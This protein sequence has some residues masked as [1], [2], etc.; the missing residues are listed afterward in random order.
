M[1][2]LRK[3]SQS[4]LI[5][6]SVIMLAASVAGYFIIQAVIENET[7]EALLQREEIIVK[8]IS[9]TGFLPQLYPIIEV[10]AIDSLTGSEP[11]FSRVWLTDDSEGETEAYIEYVRQVRIRDVN[12]VIILRQAS[13]ESEDTITALAV[14]LL[15]LLFLAFATSFLLTGRIN[16][17]MWTDFEK[18]LKLIENFSFIK[19]A[20][21][22]LRKSGIEE[23]NRLNTVVEKLTHRLRHDY[24]S[25]KEFTENASHE[26]QTPLS[27]TLINLEEILQQDIDEKTFRIVNASIA[28]LKK[29]S[30]LNK[31]LILLTKIENG[32]FVANN[33]LDLGTTIN[34][35]LEE[36][37]SL[38]ESKQI[39]VEFQQK[40]NFSVKMNE[41]LAEVLAGN[42]LSNAIRHNVQGGVVRISVTPEAVAICNS[43]GDET[44][45]SENIFR[46]FTKGSPDSFGLG[47][48]IARDICIASGLVIRYRKNEMHCFLIELN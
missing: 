28:A 25:L 46:R 37:R 27:V 1:K 31:S 42:L 48:A 47:L 15:A 3:I 41:H 4:Y 16:R 34:N 6:F 39:K 21:L 45:D 5:L 29:L 8:Q 7:R 26:I 43:G 22:E 11:V 33:I 40:G 12:Y 2:F 32:Q 18:N 36:L 38:F 35:K 20:G 30:N 17:N 24:L 13:F 9:E 10:N 23:F 19:P 44:L 14:T